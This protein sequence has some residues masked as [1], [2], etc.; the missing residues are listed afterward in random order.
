MLLA[1]QIQC[2]FKLISRNVR[3]VN[4]QLTTCKRFK[5]FLITPEKHE[6]QIIKVNSF[7]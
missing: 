5:N 2:Y 1:Q 4:V 6:I 7:E 3:Y